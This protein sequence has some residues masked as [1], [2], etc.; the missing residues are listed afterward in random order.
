MA[1]RMFLPPA[2]A[3]EINVVELF[4]DITV[5]SSGAPTPTNGTALGY[6]KG[7]STVVRNSAGRYTITLSDSYPKFLTLDTKLVSA[8]YDPTTAAAGN[9][10][11]SEAVNTATPT[12]V[13]QFYKGSDGTALDVASGSRILVMTKLRNSSIS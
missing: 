8:T 5:G 11:V 10:I 2:G 7:I 13:I 3:L 4:A 12:I 1:N 6:G 9:F